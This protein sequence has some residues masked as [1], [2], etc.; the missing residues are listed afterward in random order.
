[1][2]CPERG[3]FAGFVSNGVSRRGPVQALR[4][5]VSKGVN[6]GPAAAPVPVPLW[7]QS[8]AFAY[9]EPRLTG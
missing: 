4:A 7:V 6:D 3:N 1:M 8:L 2:L 5:V 9:R